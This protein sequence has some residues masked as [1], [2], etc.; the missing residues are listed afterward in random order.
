MTQRYYDF[1]K[2]SRFG[3]IMRYSPL[4]LENDHNFIQWIFPTTT[5]SRFSHNAPVIDIEE[6]RSHPDFEEA[7]KKMS[8]S[9]NLMLRHWGLKPKDNNR[10]L[11]LKGH[12]GLRFSRVL[13][14]LVYH[15]RVDDAASILCFVMLQRIRIGPQIDRSGLTIWETRFLEALKE[16]EDLETIDTT[17]QII[18]HMT[19][20]L[21]QSEMNDLFFSRSNHVNQSEEHKID[22]TENNFK[23]ED[24]F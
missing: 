14:S 19:D 5:P 21:E 23:E 18:G 10:I 3:E 9:L 2:S 15:N 20:D 17:N 24:D 22:N 13:Q 8:E 16:V 6:L 7:R 12:N 11:L 1:L 4:Q